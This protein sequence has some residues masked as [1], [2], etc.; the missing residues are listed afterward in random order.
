MLGKMDDDFKKQHT[1]TIMNALKQYPC[2]LLMKD[3]LTGYLENEYNSDIDDDL[4]NKA[5]EYINNLDDEDMQ[6]IADDLA[7]DAMMDSFWLSIDNWFDLL[8]EELKEK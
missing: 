4:R 1:Q 7:T 2:L 5:I 6:S 8:F 3:D